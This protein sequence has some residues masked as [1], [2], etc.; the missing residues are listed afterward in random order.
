MKN[1]G[2]PHC[3]KAVYKAMCNKQTSNEKVRY[4]YDMDFMHAE[5]L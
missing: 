4:R 1:E 5:T 3:M 2:F